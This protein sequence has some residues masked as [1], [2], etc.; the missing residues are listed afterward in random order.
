M[1]PR[2]RPIAVRDRLSLAP[3]P[4]D[5]L[6][7]RLRGLDRPNCFNHKEL[8]FE[9]VGIADALPR[10]FGELIPLDFTGYQFLLRYSTRCPL[11]KLQHSGQS[12]SPII[13]SQTRISFS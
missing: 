4:S 2:R 3:S 7:S 6:S 5:K 1:Q 12:L 10:R 11:N 8:P 13:G 9:S